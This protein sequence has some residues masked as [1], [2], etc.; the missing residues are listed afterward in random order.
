M[1]RILLALGGVTLALLAGMYLAGRTVVEH[2]AGEALD[3]LRL[4]LTPDARLAVEDVTAAPDLRGVRLRGIE[5]TAGGSTIQIGRAR[6]RGGIW[7]FDGSSTAVRRVTL[8]NLN[9]HAGRADTVRAE[10]IRL[11]DVELGREADPLRAAAGRVDRFSANVGGGHLAASTLTLAEL[12]PERLGRIY[13]SQA[14]V[15]TGG[16]SD[17]TLRVAGLGLRDVALAAIAE[18]LRGT[19]ETAGERALGTLTTGRIAATSRGVSR[20]VA[21]HLRVS[22]RR[23][24]DRALTGRVRLSGAVDGRG[25]AGD[26]QQDRLTLD[27]TPV[28][29]PD[30]TTIDLNDVALDL[31]D[32]GRVTGHAR[33]DRTTRR[34]PDSRAPDSFAAIRLVD[35][36]LDMRGAGVAR[37]L[38]GNGRG[39]TG[40]N[41]GL[42]DLDQTDLARFG[43]TADGPSRHAA[44]ALARFLRD[45]DR[46]H[47]EASPSTP[48]PVGELH[49]LARKMP[50]RLI[51]ATQ[52]RIRRP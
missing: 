11:R 10:R 7:P 25:P 47:V 3:T 1:P 32:G 16:T 43:R 41:T 13:A 33:L 4:R 31:P 45:G 38:G 12:T 27:F 30:G 39:A 15:H 17:L 9:A 28:L 2:R 20:G 21:R 5:L 35:L 19:P 50:A 44:D 46:L 23:R 29:H 34:R 18:H 52:A 51:A 42:L 37:W 8:H 26:G 24:A 48:V 36:S 22:L 6:A 49:A 40:S 14:I